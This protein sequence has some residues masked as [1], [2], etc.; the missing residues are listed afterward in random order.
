MGDKGKS[1]KSG[2]WHHCDEFEQFP[3]VS[4]LWLWWCV[5]G[6]KRTSGGTIAGNRLFGLMKQ[7][8]RIYPHADSNLFP[9]RIAKWDLSIVLDLLDFEIYQHTVPGISH[10]NSELRLQQML[11]KRGDIFLD[12]GANHGTFTLHAARLVGEEGRAIAV[13]PQPRLAEALR[14]SKEL[15]ELRQVSV[16]EAAVSD[17]AGQAMFSVPQGSSG[18]GSLFEAHARQASRASRIS[19]ATKTFAQIVE[20]TGASRLSL[21]KIDVEGAELMVFRGA[22][23][24][25]L[26]QKPFLWFEVNPKA[27]GLAGVTPASLLAFLSEL[28][29]CAFYEVS[30]VVA[31]ICAEPDEFDQLK[32]LL[33]VHTERLPEFETLKSLYLTNQN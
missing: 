30:S 7:I 19:V 17:E 1:T 23:S 5:H 32:N 12:V 2:R 20:E 15:N 14:R 22:R 18:V 33:A 27:L 28:G 11:L 25:L 6:P 26:D 10:G 3:L 8:L 21:V 4:R 24:V 29:Y 31:G 13:E 16:I 9:V